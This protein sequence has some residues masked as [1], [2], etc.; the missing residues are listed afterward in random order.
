[1]SSKE[2]KTENTALV[3]VTEDTKKKKKQ[4]KKEIAQSFV[5]GGI[6]GVIAK[7]TVAPLERIKIIFMT[8][9]ETFHY[10]AA[11]LK[12]REVVRQEG[13]KSLWRGNVIQCLRVF[14]YSS[15]VDESNK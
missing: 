7:T 9:S 1:M 2:D 13:I 6:A 15:I 14:F 4:T 3:G 5:S 8:S 12:A 11:I 10:K